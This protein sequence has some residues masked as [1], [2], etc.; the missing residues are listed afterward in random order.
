MLSS[1]FMTML[2]LG[3]EGQRADLPSLCASDAVQGRRS[4]LR[5]QTLSGRC[6]IMGQGR[7]RATV[8]VV[9]T[10]LWRR[11][12][13]GYQ[14]V[15]SHGEMPSTT[16]SKSSPRDCGVC[17]DKLPCRSARW[18]PHSSKRPSTKLGRV[19]IVNGLGRAPQSSN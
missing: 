6:H 8:C 2:A 15:H 5:G 7:L 1:M 17:Y 3:T 13:W 9:T 12:T 10:V 4:I 18:Q 19:E 11:P 14:G 16:N